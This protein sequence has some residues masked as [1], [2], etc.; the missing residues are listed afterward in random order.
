MF[1]GN[2]L[3]GWLGG[4]SSSLARRFRSDLIPD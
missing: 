4:F 3:G 1:V 2:F